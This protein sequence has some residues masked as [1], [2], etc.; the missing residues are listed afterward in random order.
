MADMA[1]AAAGALGRPVRPLRIPAGPDRGGRRPSISLRPGSPDSNPWQKCGNCFIPTGWLMTGSLA[2]ATGFAARYDLAEG[3]RH[4]IWW[5]R[6]PR[7][8]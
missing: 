7:L 5:Y 3:F 2:A 6:G 8:A 4:T 1:A